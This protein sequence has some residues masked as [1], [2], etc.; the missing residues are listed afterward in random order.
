[1]FRFENNRPVKLFFY[2]YGE[3]IYDYGSFEEKEGVL[4]YVQ[5]TRDKRVLYCG[6]Y[7]TTRRR[8][9]CTITAT[10]SCSA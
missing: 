9:K 8:A 10:A 1:M 6:E 2:E 4:L 7:L 3:F 5:Y